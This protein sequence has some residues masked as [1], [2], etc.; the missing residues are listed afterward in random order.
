[1]KK[2]GLMTW[3]TYHNYGTLLQ[4]KAMLSLIEKLGYSVKLIN[5]KPRPNY[6]TIKYSLVR[7][8]INYTKRKIVNKTTNSLIL[9]QK[10]M[11]KYIENYPKTSEVNTAPQLYALNDE[12][13]AFVCGSDQIWLS[14]AFDENY[15]LSFVQDSNKKISYAPSLGTTTIG[16]G[17]IKNKMKK[18]I[19]SIDYLSVREQQGADLIKELTSREAKVVLDPTLLLDHEDWKKEMVEINESNYIAAYFLGDNKDYIEICNKI[20][21][22]LNKK[23]FF[24]PNKPKDLLNPNTTKNDIGPKEFL[25][26][27]D[28]ADLVLTDSFHGMIFSIN[29]KKD[30][31]AFK[32]FKDNTL[33]QN[34]R[35]INILKKLELMDH[36]YEDNIEET[37]KSSLNT[38]YS[39]VHD[40]LNILKKDS[41]NFLVNA[42]EKSTN[43]D[44]THNKIHITNIC[45]GCGVCAISCPQKCINIIK[46]ENGFYEYKINHN[47]CIRCGI[48]KKVCAQHNNKLEDKKIATKL[49]YSGCSVSKSIIKKSASGGICVNIAKLYLKNNSKVISCGYDYNEQQAKMIVLDNIKDLELIQGS[50]YLQAFTVDA[51]KEI[52]NIDKG[53]IIGTPCQI[54]S[55]DL[56]LKMINKR[57]SF[58]LID[59]ICHGVPTDLLWK[60]YIQD[61]DTPQKISFRN[62]DKGWHCKVMEINTATKKYI[63]SEKKDIF[64]HFFNIGNIYNKCCYEC[65]YRKSSC[66]DIRVG[67]YWGPKFKNNLVG[68]SMIIPL[69]EL[70]ERTIEEL[71]NEKIIDLNQ[72]NIKDYFRYQQSENIRINLNYEEIMDDLKNNS[73]SLLEID[74]KYN[75]KILHKQKF[76]KIVDKIRYK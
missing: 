26:I 64:Y 66:A 20:A 34:S 53:V 69:T 41:I 57:N 42:L 21:K 22:K 17:I 13:D 52:K 63:K 46:N 62:K 72:E 60:K 74:K 14:S 73:I 5:Y 47:K 35:I 55:L 51:Y 45:T 24:I 36:L 38:D 33:S 29:F 16:N 23:L 71:V 19:S 12:F 76:W 10:N 27:I 50:K 9:E 11:D 39:I 67:D 40:K 58:L 30:F 54:A 56:Y 48:C 59:F 1:M 28:S 4:C 6:K 44:I 61:F 8:G 75:K 25:S 31:I 7:K 65:K 43:Y 32:R 2:I 49:L 15:F 70:G 18:L 68:M 37:L 3:F